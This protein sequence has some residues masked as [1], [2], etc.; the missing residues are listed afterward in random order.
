MNKILK[1]LHGNPKEDLMPVWLWIL[2]VVVYGIY[3]LGSII[4]V[5]K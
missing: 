1:W 5:L 3:T 4:E 2:T